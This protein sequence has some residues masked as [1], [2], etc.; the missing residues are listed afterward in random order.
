MD[1]LLFT[2]VSDSGVSYEIEFPLHPDTNSADAVS[3]LASE[4]LATISK[5]I[6]ES[7]ILKDGDIIQAL[8]MACV[9]RNRM[10]NVDSKLA[11]DVLLDLIRQNNQ[12]VLNAKQVIASRA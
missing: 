5:C 2:T 9:I 7:K 6:H 1:Y 8:S 12:A 4:L 10:I 11:E 3:I